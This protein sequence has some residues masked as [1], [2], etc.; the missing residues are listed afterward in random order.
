MPILGLGYEALSH[1]HERRSRGIYTWVTPFQC[2]PDP[3]LHCTSA[4]GNFLLLPLSAFGRHPTGIS[5]GSLHSPRRGRSH[6][7][8]CWS[9]PNTGKIHRSLSFRGSIT[10][11]SGPANTHTCE[12]RW[13]A[14]ENLLT[15]TENSQL[16]IRETRQQMSQ[17][18]RATFAKIAAKLR[19]TGRPFATGRSA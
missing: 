19:A 18:L 10:L 17:P 2:A 1:V 3:R 8:P 12:A 16:Y 13:A 9:K 15:H 14:R 7:Q 4:A 5:T 6:L 11:P